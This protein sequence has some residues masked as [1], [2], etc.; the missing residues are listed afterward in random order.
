MHQLTLPIRWLIDAYSYP[1]SN[2]YILRHSEFNIKFISIKNLRHHLAT[3]PSALMIRVKCFIKTDKN[4]LFAWV[5]SDNCF[6]CQLPLKI[7]PQCVSNIKDNHIKFPEFCT[8]QN[9]MIRS[10]QRTIFFKKNYGFL[11]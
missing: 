6:N 1:A 8:F 9:Q 5:I 11:I 4:E 2:T 10:K 3:V 7:H